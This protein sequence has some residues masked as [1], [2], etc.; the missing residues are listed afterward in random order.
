[1]HVVRKKDCTKHP[2][3]HKRGRNGLWQCKHMS[4]SRHPYHR[5]RPGQ[6]QQRS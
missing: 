2:G 3:E 4:A 5:E 1:M 6:Q